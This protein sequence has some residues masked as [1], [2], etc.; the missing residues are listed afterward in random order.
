M[1]V[2]CVLH[3]ENAFFRGEIPWCSTCPTWMQD[4]NCNSTEIPYNSISIQNGI[5]SR[6]WEV[7][8]CNAYTGSMQSSWIIRSLWSLVPVASHIQSVINSCLFRNTC[9][10]MLTDGLKNPN[11]EKKLYTIYKLPRSSHNLSIHSRFTHL[12]THIEFHKTVYWLV[13]RV[14]I[15]KK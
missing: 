10:Y 9:T 2:V 1:Y 6:L 12:L 15:F 5:K 11:A 8:I 3:W 13:A 14:R 7:R 4:T